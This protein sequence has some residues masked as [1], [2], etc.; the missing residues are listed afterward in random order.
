MTNNISDNLINNEKD[1]KLN[2]CIETYYFDVIIISVIMEITKY[3]S[4]YDKNTSK[5]LDIKYETIRL[6]Q[7]KIESNK[8]ITIEQIKL[9]Q[10]NSEQ[11]KLEKQIKLEQIKLEQNK[12]ESEKQIKLEQIKL[13]QIKLEIELAKIKQS[14]NNF[15]KKTR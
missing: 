14:E 5:M 1:E 8:E 13:E 10:I 2:L 7:I 11:I 12:L 15:N 4:L 9:E 6:E 3:N